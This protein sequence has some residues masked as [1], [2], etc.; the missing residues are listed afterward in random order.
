MCHILKPRG[1]GT[2]HYFGAGW[3]YFYFAIAQK[4]AI[5]LLLIWTFYQASAKS[6]VHHKHN[7]TKHTTTN[8]SRRQPTL[9]RICH[10]STWQHQP[11]PQILTQRYLRVRCRCPV[12]GSRSPLHVPSFGV[13]THTPSKNRAMVVVLTFGGCHFMIRH[14]NQPDSRWSGRGCAWAEARGGGTWGGAIPSFGLSNW[15]TKKY[16]KFILKI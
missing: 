13:P 10:L 3:L 7:N 11:W 5:L 12:A 15:S 14:N 8:M 4:L 6:T 9:Q 16:R 1:G 2:C